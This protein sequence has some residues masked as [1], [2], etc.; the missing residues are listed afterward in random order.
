MKRRDF[1]KYGAAGLATAGAG[2]SPFEV[3]AQ[4]LP[5]TAEIKLG[6]TDVE[7]R[8]IDGDK[9]NMLA[10][11]LDGGAGALAT[12][13]VPG[14]VLR[15]KEG[16][17]VK[18]IV[19]NDRQETHGFEITGIPG[20]K[21]EIAAG[22]T[23]TI[24][25]QA[26]MAGTYIYHDGHGGTPLYRILGLH[27]I[28][29]VEP[30]NGTTP[31]GS[32]T[33]Y[34]LDKLAPQ[35]YA[36]VSALFDALG[37]TERF[38]GGADG[39]WMPAPSNAEASIREKIWICA[40]IDPKFNALIERGKQIASSPLTANVVDTFVPR[41]FTINNRSGYD[42]HADYDGQLPVIAKNYIGEPTLFRIVN[43]GLAHHANHFHG[44]H[45]MELARVDLNPKSTTYGQI[46]VPDNIFEVDTTAMWPMQRR[47]LLLPFEIPPD[48]PYQIPVSGPTG[49]QFQRMV[50]KQAQEPFPLRYVMHCHTEMSQTAAGGNYPQGMVCHWE[51]LGG[52]GGR[53]KA[54]G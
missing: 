11:R 46:I 12:G 18:I 15:V 8:L 21:T 23:A 6:I 1:L 10:F 16:S 28:L 24:A 2:L 35:S 7:T 49:S 13:R 54:T 17:L 32:R 31:A 20:A 3:L 5:G 4:A 44:N 36:A 37:T 33:P 38:Q 27:G 29:V 19:T 42:L 43:V 25:F 40:G 41:Y 30:L 22:S 39:K 9:V 48:I 45:L 52:L 34:S 26:P 47:D 51:V 14:P 50:N 53:A